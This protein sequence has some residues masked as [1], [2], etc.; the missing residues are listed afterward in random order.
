[1]N[2]ASGKDKQMPYT[3][4]MLYMLELVEDNANHVTEAAD[5]QK[6]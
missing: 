4:H 6:F 1:M 5:N 2:H 3:V